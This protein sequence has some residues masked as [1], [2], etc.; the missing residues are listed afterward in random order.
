MPVARRGEAPEHAVGMKGGSCLEGS[1]LSRWGNIGKGSRIKERSA[2]LYHRLATTQ[3][4]SF[5]TRGPRELVIKDL[6]KIAVVRSLG[7]RG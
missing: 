2:I 5:F 7:W 3:D 1:R 6:F 4:M